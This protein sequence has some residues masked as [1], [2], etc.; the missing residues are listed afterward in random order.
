MNIL[1]IDV[2]NTRTHYGIVNE[3]T[4]L[5][6]GH[7]HT[8]HFR[9]SASG[10]F[11]QQL[12]PLLKQ[13]D[14]IAY[15][16]VVPAINSNLLASLPQNDLPVFHLTHFN[17]NGLNIDYPKPEEIGQDRLA[18][19][20]A[21]KHYYNIPAIILDMGTAIT[22]DV[23][24]STGYEGGIIAPGLAL[25]TRYLH[26]E[27]ALLPKIEESNLQNVTGYIGKSTAHA[28]QLGAT[29]GFTGMIDALIERVFTELKAR[30][31]EDPTLLLTGGNV[32]H[33]N[34]KWAQAFKLVENLTLIG[35][36]AAFRFRNNT[37]D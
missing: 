10:L 22:L 20:I 4:V 27:T 17:C 21:A 8:K 2:G 29:I 5:E 35:L 32:T 1:C 7:F 6:T 16:S 26:E 3:Q 14:G 30:T 23:V 12:T 24:S 25:M 33:L 36:A 34:S 37:K 13:V 28:M 15:C 31:K 18:S 9:S 19:A 11:S